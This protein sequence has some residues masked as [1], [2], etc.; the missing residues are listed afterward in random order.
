MGIMS[1]LAKSGLAKKAVDE[2]RKPQN[3][4]KIKDAISNFSNKGKGSGTKPR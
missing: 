4:Q 3:Q 1:K 2:A